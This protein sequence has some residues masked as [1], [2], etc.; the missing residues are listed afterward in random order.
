MQSMMC[1]TCK[2]QLHTVRA[3]VYEGPLWEIEALL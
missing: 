1:D 3:N 2:Y